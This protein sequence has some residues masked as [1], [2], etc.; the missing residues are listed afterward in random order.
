LELV[1]HK[2]VSLHT[3]ETGL[4][5]TVMQNLLMDYNIFFVS[6]ET[7]IQEGRE[8]KQKLKTLLNT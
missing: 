3:Y 5:F 2:K 4:S 8:K 7:N 6:Q 1:I